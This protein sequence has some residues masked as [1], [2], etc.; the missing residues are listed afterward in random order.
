MREGEDFD[1][2]DLLAE[3]NARI[4]V[5][6][7]REPIDRE[8]KLWEFVCECAHVRCHERVALCLADYEVL[9][10]T[11][12]PVLAPRHR[13]PRRRRTRFARRLS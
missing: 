5:V 3:V 6:A 10:Q 9:R 4:R 7:A 2:P 13:L 8:V 1:L 11:G 12:A